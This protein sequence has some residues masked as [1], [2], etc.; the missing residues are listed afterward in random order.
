MA[1]GWEPTLLL[2]VMTV[3][4][5]ERGLGVAIGGAVDVLVFGLG[6]LTVGWGLELGWPTA[7]L[8]VTAAAMAADQVARVGGRSPGRDPFRLLAR[9]RSKVGFALASLA[10][11]AVWSIGLVLA[12]RALGDVGDAVGARWLVGLL[13]VVALAL[14]TPGVRPPGG[15]SAPLWRTRR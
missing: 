14:S 15:Q 7:A 4:F 1:F 10:S 2:V 13:V 6:A 5:A 8:W 12:G 11:A 3:V 9:R